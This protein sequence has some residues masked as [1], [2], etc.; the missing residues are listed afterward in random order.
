[1]SP[2]WLLLFFRQGKSD[3]TGQL[4]GLGRFHAMSLCCPYCSLVLSLQRLKNF[5]GCFTKFCSH[6]G[7]CSLA[8]SLEVFLMCIPTLSIYW[9]LLCLCWWSHVSGGLCT[10]HVLHSRT[11]LDP[12]PGEATCYL[13]VL[14]SGHISS[15]CHTNWRSAFFLLVALALSWVQNQGRGDYIWH[16]MVKG[17]KNPTNQTKIK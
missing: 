3:L 17:N 7:L 2:C 4:Q 11:E 9:L 1:M 15:L 8:V 10:P 16:E 5:L 13:H 6:G 12:L 14:C